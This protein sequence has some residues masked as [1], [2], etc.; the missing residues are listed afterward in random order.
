MNAAF[1][2][3]GTSIGGRKGKSFNR[4]AERERKM[5]LIRE[6]VLNPVT[7]GVAEIILIVAA[8]PMVGWSWAVS[9]MAGPKVKNAKE[10]T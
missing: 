7:V 5:N 4:R 3:L 10:G 1:H 8:L 9:H 2:R 6:I